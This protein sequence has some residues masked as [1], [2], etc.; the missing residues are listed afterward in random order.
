MWSAKNLRAEAC[1]CAARPRFTPLQ[2]IRNSIHE[3]VQRI[4]ECEHAHVPGA[5][6][7]VHTGAGITTCLD[8]PLPSY[9]LLRA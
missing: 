5:T 1:R 3:T 6:L 4:L 9:L 2:S 8:T 7:S